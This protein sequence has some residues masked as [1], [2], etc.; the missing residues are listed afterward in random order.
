MYCIEWRSLQGFELI[1][2]I[3]GGV[4]ARGSLAVAHHLLSLSL[5]EAPRPDL[6]AAC[7]LAGDRSWGSASFLAGLAAGVLLVLLVQAF[8]TLRWAVIS[9]AHWRCNGGF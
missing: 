5:I 1:R 8:C 4:S 2:S 6:L 7:N 3:A 9:Y